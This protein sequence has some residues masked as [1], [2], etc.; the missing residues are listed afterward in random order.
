MKAED[1][2][3]LVSQDE[4]RRRKGEYLEKLLNAEEERQPEIGA[5][6][7]DTRVMY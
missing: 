1:D 7:R 5:S 3:L 2:R 6:G 4:T